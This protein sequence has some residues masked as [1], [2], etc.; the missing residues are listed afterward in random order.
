MTS[1]HD[2]HALRDATIGAANARNCTPALAQY[3]LNVPC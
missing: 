3:V 2:P 1:E